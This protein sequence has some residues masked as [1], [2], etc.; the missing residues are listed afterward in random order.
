MA[1]YFPVN[2]L[3]KLLF[4]SLM[5]DYVEQELE[6]LNR[7]TKIALVTVFWSLKN[8]SVFNLMSY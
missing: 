1:H 6:S 4:S 3:D 8:T 7:N 2:V 5:S